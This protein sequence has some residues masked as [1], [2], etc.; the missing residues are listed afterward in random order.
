MKALMLT[1][2]LLPGLALGQDLREDLDRQWPLQPS[3]A[4]QAIQ[5]VALTP[6]VYAGI[7]R[8]DASDLLVLDANGLQLPANLQAAAE[9]PMAAQWRSLPWFVLPGSPAGQ[10][11]D[12][13]VLVRRDAHGRVTDVLNRLQAPAA[14]ATPTRWLARARSATS[15]WNC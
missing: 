5:Q 6:A 15:R 2:L 11:D 4:A 3:A 14:S 13:S 7:A 1:A 12:L 10:G 9:Q 8:H